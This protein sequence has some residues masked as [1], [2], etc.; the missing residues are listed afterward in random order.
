MI[1]SAIISPY[2]PQYAAT[3][4][5]ML[6]S[7]E[8]RARPYLAWYWRTQ[9]FSQV[10]KR[11]QLR[12]TRAAWLLLLAVYAGM[13]LQIA[14]GLFLIALWH[15]HGLAGGWAFGLAL[16]ISYPVIWA[17][18]IVV[19]LILGRFL[20]VMPREKRAI[21]ASERIFKDHKGAKIAI[22]G[23][24]GKTSMK[25]LLLTVF[26]EGKEVAATPA[27][28]NVAI[29][30]ARF[31]QTLTGGED[32]LLIEYGEGAPGDVTR[33]ARRT[34]PTHAVITGVAAAH[35]DQYKTVEA[36][37][38]DIFSVAAAL[39]SEDTCY[40]NG[41]SPAAEPFT[42]PGFAL[43]SRGGALGW[44]VHDVTV[45]IS[46]LSFSLQKGKQAIH[47]TSGLLGRHQLGP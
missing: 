14:G 8:Y 15:W 31:A 30:H 5:Y 41:E 38:K 9:D 27:N 33:F 21:I 40:V 19:P 13:I 1:V 43:Y 32:I 7:T 36:A 37:G 46:G 44:K 47:L 45:S 4:V 39:P 2:L 18:F 25:E 20:V 26:R 28:K 34:H 35:L 6:Q 22:A 17:H 16:I 12:R 42:K 11:R 3:L 24:Y 29:S 10:A 23:S